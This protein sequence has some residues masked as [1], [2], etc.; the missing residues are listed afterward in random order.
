MRRTSRPRRP[1]IEPIPPRLQQAPYEGSV[2]TSE[3]RAA[4]SYSR[5][6]VPISLFPV[7]RVLA[8]ATPLRG[9]LRGTTPPR[10]SAPSAPSARRPP[11]RLRP[12]DRDSSPSDRLSGFSCRSV[13]RGETPPSARPSVPRLA[14]ALATG[15]PNAFAV[16][17]SIYRID[18]EAPS[19]RND[20][21][22][23]ILPAICAW[24]SIP[25][26]WSPPCAVRAVLQRNCWDRY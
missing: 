7:S 17:A 20:G 2:I 19:W 8:S 26:S 24:C 3:V 23:G 15:V 22:R 5:W 14:L 16:S 10:G 9:S 25:T 6:R 11:I 1:L 4:A 13:I 21:Q 12:S 18:D